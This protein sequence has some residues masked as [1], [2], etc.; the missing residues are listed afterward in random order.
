MCPSSADPD[1]SFKFWMSDDPENKLGCCMKGCDIP[2]A[3]NPHRSVSLR[4][5]RQRLSTDTQ[6]TAASKDPNCPRPVVC[7]RAQL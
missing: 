1:I 7:W 6:K 2:P 3:R 4:K 5:H